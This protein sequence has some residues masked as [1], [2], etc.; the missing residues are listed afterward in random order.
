VEVDSAANAAAM[1]TAPDDRPRRRRRNNKKK[2][3]EAT[4][5]EKEKQGEIGI[6]DDVDDKV[7]EDSETERSLTE[8][9]SDTEQ[10][11]PELRQRQRGGDDDDDDDDGSAS[12]S[13]SEERR[14]S[15]YDF[16]QRVSQQLIV[17]PKRAGGGTQ[18]QQQRQRQRR[19][20]LLSSM[21]TYQR[22]SLLSLG[23]SKSSNRGLAPQQQ[24]GS[25][26]GSG[27]NTTGSDRP[28]SLI[29]GTQ[30][31][32]LSVVPAAAN[33]RTPAV[34]LGF[35]YYRGSG[36]DRS[37]DDDEGM[38]SSTDETNDTAEN[39]TTLS[40]A[41]T[42]LHDR[43]R[44]RPPYYDYYGDRNNRS[45]NP[46]LSSTSV[47]LSSL[48]TPRDLLDVESGRAVVVYHDHDYGTNRGRQQQLTRPNPDRRGQKRN[49]I[50]QD[51]HMFFEAQ[52]D[53]L[54]QTM[55]Q[56][57]RGILHRRRG[58]GGRR[59]NG[60]SSKNASAAITSTMTVPVDFEMNNE[61]GLLGG[62][63][64]EILRH[65]LCLTMDDVNALR[66]SRALQLNLPFQTGYESFL[67][68]LVVETLDR[69]T[70]HDLAAV[71]AL[72][73]QNRNVSRAIV[74]SLGPRHD[75]LWHWGTAVSHNRVFDAW[76]QF[77]IV[78]I[79]QFPATENFPSTRDHALASIFRVL[80]GEGSW[81]TRVV[82]RGREGLITDNPNNVAQNLAAESN[83]FE[84]AN[85]NQYV[86]FTS[87]AFENATFANFFVHH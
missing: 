74:Q 27:S 31:L 78:G 2:P 8:R 26:G 75:F 23:R 42:N 43:H 65:L 10:Q 64:R 38:L 15:S 47:S 40:I 30:T 17:L 28:P 86:A 33:G 4:A 9:E 1:S 51:D 14:S 82:T 81:L 73:F 85:R 71:L 49:A 32:R 50:V 44:H 83:G 35:N 3:K 55:V 79:T 12:S 53:A 45:G 25:N 68:E 20:S 57:R 18:Q 60:S 67:I 46:R 29:T 76:G 54:R 66:V 11:R 36:G 77:P 63:W 41:G 58:G 13:S 21:Q 52:Q 61:V 37:D 22:N 70:E 19:P 48:R 5:G 80:L 69:G 56:Q 62:A 59:A 87:S 7:E 39:T 24:Q 34:G 72:A 84:L 16:S 6:D